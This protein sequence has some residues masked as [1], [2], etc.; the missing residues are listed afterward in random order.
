M[1]A[2]LPR[3]R[4]TLAMTK[5]IGRVGGERKQGPERFRVRPRSIAG[6]LKVTVFEEPKLILPTRV[7]S[8]LAEPVVEVSVMTESEPPTANPWTVPLGGNRERIAEGTVSCRS[9]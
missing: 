3:K 4:L 5:R 8:P 6:Y 2:S 7:S 9:E 1:V